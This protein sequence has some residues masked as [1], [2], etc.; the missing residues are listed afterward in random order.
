MTDRKALVED[1]GITTVSTAGP[2]TGASG[3]EIVSA[4]PSAR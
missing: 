1:G 3:L 4:A 2:L